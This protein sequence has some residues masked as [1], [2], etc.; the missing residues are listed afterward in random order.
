MKQEDKL[1]NSLRDYYDNQE[2]P[3]DDNEWEHASAYLSA[4]RRG[5]RIRYAALILTATI[6]SLVVGLFTLSKLSNDERRQTSS[7]SNQNL[8]SE[9]ASQSVALRALTASNAKPEISVHSN[10]KNK[11][12]GYSAH[13]M[14]SASETSRNNSLEQEVLTPIKTSQG[15]GAEVTVSEPALVT[16]QTTLK[17]SPTRDANPID[18]SV[19]PIDVTSPANSNQDKLNTPL[20]LDSK[21]NVEVIP[22]VTENLVYDSNSFQAK[23]IS[24]V[25]M[26]TSPQTAKALV[27]K[28][29]QKEI[30]TTDQIEITGPGEKVIPTAFDTARYST[31]EGVSSEIETEEEYTVTPIF[32]NLADQGIFYEVGAAWNYGWKGPVNRDARGFSPIAGINYMNRLSRRCAISFGLQYLQVNNLSNSSKTSRV[33]TYVYGESSNVT[34]VTPTTLHYLVAPLRFHY[35]INHQNCF[36]AGINLAYLLNVDTKVTSYEERPGFSGDKKTV[37]LSGYTEGFSW[38]DSQIAF[39]YRRRVTKSLAVQAEIFMGLTDIKQNEFF[40]FTNK[41]RNSGAKLSLVYF[42]F[43]KKDKK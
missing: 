43:S 17:K 7:Y 4:A 15:S 3:F 2:I 11:G 23:E 22:P 37:K 29:K 13:A 33:S 42:A 5:R 27:L 12:T 32:N 34:V 25:P 14:I 26:K 10:P 1:R 8:K 38:F 21:E 20:E 19:A 16:R 36:G 30:A 6:F 31:S 9:P 35:Y 24:Q 39:F 40:G 41:E 28:D 18:A